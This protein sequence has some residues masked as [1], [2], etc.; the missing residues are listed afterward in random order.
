MK[1]TEAGAPSIDRGKS[2]QKSLVVDLVDEENV[3]AKR[4]MNDNANKGLS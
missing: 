2:N 4:M 1:N 3:D